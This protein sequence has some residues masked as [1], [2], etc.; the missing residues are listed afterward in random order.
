MKSRRA[1]TRTLGNRRHIEGPGREPIGLAEQWRDT[2]RIRRILARRIGGHQEN[3]GAVSG[4]SLCGGGQCHPGC[5][6][7]IRAFASAGGYWRK[8]RAKRCNPAHLW[9]ERTTPGV[10]NFMPE[11]PVSFPA[12]EPPLL[13]LPEDELVSF[14]HL[15][16]SAHELAR[17]GR[18]TTALDCLDTGFLYALE[19]EMEGEAWGR[20]LVQCYRAAFKSFE[21]RYGGRLVE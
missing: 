12:L 6:R 7:S 17:E 13:Q 10:H 1:S 14:L 8:D 3:G 21:W 15:V 5:T 18:I 9:G 4:E 11:L 2:H 19:S 16:L 20:A